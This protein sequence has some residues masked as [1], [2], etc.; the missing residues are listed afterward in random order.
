MKFVKIFYHQSLDSIQPITEE[1]TSVNLKESIEK[2][3]QAL[4]VAYAGFDNAV[5]ENLIDSYIYEINALQKR[6]EHLT[7]LAAAQP[8]VPDKKLCVHPAI[9]ALV[10]HVF[11]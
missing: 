7:L 1:L 10:S 11:G 9:R 5:D 8:A 6:Y 4:E 2:T 3:R